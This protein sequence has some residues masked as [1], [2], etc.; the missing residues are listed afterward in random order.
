MVKKADIIICA[1]ISLLLEKHYQSRE[2]CYKN[3]LFT[4]DE[5][6]KRANELIDPN[7]RIRDN[8][9]LNLTEGKGI[10]GD[11]VEK[12]FL[13]G[14]KG[15]LGIYY[16][17]G[18]PGEINDYNILK[19]IRLLKS[20]ISETSFS[21]YHTDNEMLSILNRYFDLLQNY[22]TAEQS[23]C[24]ELIAK[25]AIWIAT[26]TLAYNE[27]HRTNSM[28]RDSYFFAQSEI[29]KTAHTYNMN[30]SLD[31]C[32]QMTRSDCTDREKYLVAKEQKRRLA[33]WGETD[34]ICPVNN[35]D[36]VV[37]TVNGEKTISEI[38]SFFEKEY[39]NIFLT[40]L[41]CTV[42][43]SIEEVEKYAVSLSDRVLRYI[44]INRGSGVSSQEER[45]VQYYRRDPYISYYAKRWANGICQ[46][47]K[48]QAPFINSNGEP[49]LESHHILPLSEGGRDAVDNVVA[50]CPNCHRKMHILRKNEDVRQLM[51]IVKDAIKNRIKY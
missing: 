27:Y 14:G 20:N 18:F 7:K 26:A 8:E 6:Q 9:L 40:E 25:E 32:R 19:Y 46:L 12:F 50:L 44:A 47:C 38:I 11:S 36:F 1:W 10:C 49:Y 23:K 2:V 21:F 35:N 13:I 51:N 5:I 3:L 22:T 15:A 34:V 4:R 45:V 37:L 28:I 29:A 42:E 39:T 16:R 24:A 33:Y 48:A 43:G 41:L 31:T 17:L 30:N